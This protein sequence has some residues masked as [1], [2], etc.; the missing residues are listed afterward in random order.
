MSFPCH[1]KFTKIALPKS[2]NLLFERY[3]VKSIYAMNCNITWFH[4][5]FVKSGWT[6]YFP[7][8]SRKKKDFC[9]QKQKLLR[10][11]LKTQHSTHFYCFMECKKKKPKGLAGLVKVL[12]FLLVLSDFSCK[13]LWRYLKCYILFTYLWLEF[14][15]NW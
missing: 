2:W 9:E 10:E 14:E 12:I 4:R 15:N 3:F 6:E 11:P 1:F 8:V 5:I 13:I 7:S